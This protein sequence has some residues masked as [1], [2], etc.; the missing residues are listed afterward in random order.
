MTDQLSLEALWAEFLHNCQVVS[1]G[2]LTVTPH[3][4]APRRIIGPAGRYSRKSYSCNEY[5]CINGSLL[6]QISEPEDMDFLHQE[7]LRFKDHNF[8]DT[9]KQRN[10]HVKLI[11]RSQGDLPSSPARPPNYNMSFKFEH[12]RSIHG[13]CS[14]RAGAPCYAWSMAR[15]THG[16]TTIQF[17]HMT[18]T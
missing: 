18:P 8:Y 13:F 10:D 11:L 6:V 1:G 15:A 17:A 7:V 9:I 12:G 5:G 16:S 2:R 4:F 3:G 14:L